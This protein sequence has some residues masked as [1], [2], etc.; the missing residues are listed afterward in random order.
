M[1]TT[2]KENPDPPP[3]S[4]AEKT[5][6]KFKLAPVDRSRYTVFLMHLTEDMVHHT[7]KVLIELHLD[8]LIADGLIPDG[9]MRNGDTL[10]VS[11]KD[12]TK[13]TLKRMG[14]RTFT[15]KGVPVYYLQDD[16]PMVIVNIRGNDF[17]HPMIDASSLV[18]KYGKI[19]HCYR[20]VNEYRGNRYESGIISVWLRDV[21]TK[22]PMKFDKR[23]SCF[24]NKEK[25]DI[26]LIKT[27]VKAAGVKIVSETPP[28]KAVV[29][30]PARTGGIATTDAAS[31]EP[32]EVRHVMT[33]DTEVVAA[34]VEPTQTRQCVDA[35]RTTF[36]TTVAASM[37]PTE[38]RQ[39]VVAERTIFATTTAASVD[40]GEVRQARLDKKYERKW[41]MYP[42]IDRMNTEDYELAEGYWDMPAAKQELL[43]A[44][45][46]DL[47]KESKWIP[48]WTE[49]KAAW[50][51]QPEYE[52]G[53]HHQCGLCSKKFHTLEHLRFH[54]LKKHADS[55]TDDE[56]MEVIDSVELTPDQLEAVRTEV[57]KTS[58]PG[59]QMAILQTKVLRD[60]KKK[61]MMKRHQEKHGASVK[62]KAAQKK[63]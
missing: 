3:L 17:R 25:V 11:F 26:M 9:I 21:H 12:P 8:G 27:A 16:D 1:A 46:N 31:V 18:T 29:I 58:A 51:K 55:A 48:R 53:M 28:V 22:I 61:E 57:E 10:E 44:I 4:T 30:P 19:V 37:E 62:K 43:M 34:S 40:H 6:T 41:R 50:N 13:E 52:E 54:A 38:A 39:P 47:K 49:V 45:F 36:A 63:K 60:F 32:S 42:A 59:A 14:C 33:K 15:Q 56:D 35:G 23:R 20:Q 24:Y 2:S 7:A 5:Q